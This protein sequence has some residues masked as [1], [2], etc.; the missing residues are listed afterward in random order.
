MKSLAQGTRA[1]PRRKSRANR[2]CP[3]VHH[4]SRKGATPLRLS[5]AD[6]SSPTEQR[7][8]ERVKPLRAWSDEEDDLFDNEV[9]GDLTPS[10]KDVRKDFSSFMQ[11]KKEVK[12]KGKTPNFPPKECYLVFLSLSLSLCVCVCVCVC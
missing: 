6:R 12:N 7:R 11:K 3:R 2:R 9:E 4:A 5:P 1:G 10:L 8:A